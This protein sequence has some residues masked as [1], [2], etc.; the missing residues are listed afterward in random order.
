MYR[1]QFFLL[2]FLFFF[3]QSCAEN[4]T[5]KNN[6]N[7]NKKYYSSLGFTLI[8][9]QNLFDNK[10][11]NKK[12]NNESFV[13]LHKNLKVNTK[14]K[15]IN[16]INSKIVETKVS[17]KANYPNLFNSVINKKIASAL[18]LDPENP[19]VEIYEIKKNKTFI[20][21]EGTIF[22]EEKNVADKAPINDVEMNDLTNNDSLNLDVNKNNKN[23]ILL[24]SD[25]YYI[26]SALK[27]KKNL[28][29]KT[30]IKSFLVKK[31]NNTKYRLLA[32]PFENFSALKSTY[33]SL[34]NLGFENLDI[35]MD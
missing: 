10:I 12:I 34:N 8:Y 22:D 9:D 18:D 35:L 28:I 16:P 23:F 4:L 15:I 33:I 27:L 14:V 19:Y 21:K 26:D 31:I 20:A 5:Y 7:S 11:I 29:E 17:K 13:F 2:I 3:L 30:N 24:V 6:T 1:I 25:F 32:G